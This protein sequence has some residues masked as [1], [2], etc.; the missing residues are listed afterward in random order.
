MTPEEFKEALKRLGWKQT[1]F[2][3]K[4][5]MGTSSIT[6][7]VSGDTPVPEWAARYLAAMQRIADLHAEFVVPEKPGSE[8]QG[9]SDES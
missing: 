4:A 8:D 5:G 2:A 6:R 1:D 3:R 9:Q 7:W